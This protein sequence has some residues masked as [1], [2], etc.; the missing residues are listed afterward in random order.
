LYDTE[1]CLYEY[2]DFVLVATGGSIQCIIHGNFAHMARNVL[3][4]VSP[5]TN[6]KYE[7]FI[8]SNKCSKLDDSQSSRCGRSVS[9]DSNDDETISY[10]SLVSGEEVLLNMNSEIE[11][12]RSI[13]DFKNLNKIGEG[14][15]GTVYQAKDLKSGD[16]VAIKRVRCDV[17]LEMS[18]MRE[19]AILKRTKHKNI[20]ALREIAIGQSLNSVFLVMEYCEH[21]LGSLLDWMKLPFSESDVKCLIYQLLEGVDY[22][23][24]NYIVHRDLKASNLL[25]KDDGTL[26]ISD[27]GLARTC[28]KPEPRMTPKVVTIWYRAPELL[29]E[30]EHITSAIDIWATACVFG[31]L[32][33]H[34]PLF[35]GTGEIDQ[36]RL[37]IDLLGSP[38]EKIWPD[39]VNLPVTRSFSF[40]KQPYNKLKNLFPTMSSNGIKLLNTMFAYDP[41]KRATAKQCLTSAYFKEQPFPTNPRLMSSYPQTHNTYSGRKDEHNR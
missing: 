35:P 29:F 20:I 13:Y 24:S 9:N 23:H 41:E 12:C 3:C 30:S 25:L 10:V 22:L 5:A 27:F 32:L 11:K 2:K 19:I 6:C 26:K 8:P 34:K 28:G 37:I 38:N 31:E 40:K 17:G 7:A 1:I 36:I 39:F 33:L 14:A 18:T 15:Y 4:K 21:D 16:I